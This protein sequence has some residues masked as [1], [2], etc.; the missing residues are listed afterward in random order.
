MYSA[1]SAEY[2]YCVVRVLP[3][4]SEPCTKKKKS[5]HSTK[6]QH[7]KQEKITNARVLLRANDVR[8]V[9]MK[10]VTFTPLMSEVGNSIPDII[11]GNG[12][13]LAYRPESIKSCDS[14]SNPLNPLIRCGLK[15]LWQAYDFVPRIV[16]GVRCPS[17][18]SSYASWPFWVFASK[19]WA[20]NMSS[21]VGKNRLC[22]KQLP[23]GYILTPSS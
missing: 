8:G 22:L 6:E 20:K 23:I 12:N 13:V 3:A 2:M 15:S 14:L 18:S 21:R 5:S 4:E 9:L 7:P 1:Q 16:R 17:S 10:S 19:T 11:I